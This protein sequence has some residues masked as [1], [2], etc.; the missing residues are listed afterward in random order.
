MKTAKYAERKSVVMKDGLELG[1]AA[2]GTV[3]S[4][5]LGNPTPAGQRN[6]VVN[7]V[8]HLR[9]KLASALLVPRKPLENYLF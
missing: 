7:V 2:E 1:Q 6:K 3:I 8:I 5:N 9:R 4:A